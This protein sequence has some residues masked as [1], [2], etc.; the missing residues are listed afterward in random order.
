MQALATEMF[1]VE[2]IIGLKIIKELFSPNVSP[3]DLHNDNSFKRRRVNS[4]AWH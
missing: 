3:Y 4:L 2:D 1:K